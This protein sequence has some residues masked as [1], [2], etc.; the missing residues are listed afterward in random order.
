MMF[1]DELLVLSDVDV[2]V[3]KGKDGVY[4]DLWSLDG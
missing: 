1:F 3:G 2:S 4:D